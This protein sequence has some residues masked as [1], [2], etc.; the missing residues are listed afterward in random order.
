MPTVSDVRLSCFDIKLVNSLVHGHGSSSFLLVHV[1]LCLCWLR[2]AGLTTASS[3]RDL[4]ITKPTVSTMRTIVQSP[5]PH[6]QGSSWLASAHALV[7]CIVHS[8]SSA[9]VKGWRH[10]DDTERRLVRNMVKEGIHWVTI[11]RTTLLYFAKD[12]AS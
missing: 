5:T 8:L 2:R 12:F 10:V 9:M 3:F 11:Q 4:D 1:H 7:A 6:S